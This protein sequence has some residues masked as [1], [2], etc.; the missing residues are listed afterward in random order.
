M[1]RRRMYA[2]RQPVK[3]TADVLAILNESDAHI[4]SCNRVT[5]PWT[6]WRDQ[7]PRP[8]KLESLKGCTKDVTVQL[9]HK[10]ANATY[11]CIQARAEA[12]R[13][14]RSLTDAEEQALATQLKRISDALET[15]RRKALPE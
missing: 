9:G 11:S 12:V 8:C 4:E 6:R 1:T 15:M 2:P 3:F 5:F 7:Q 13:G 14:K 10:D